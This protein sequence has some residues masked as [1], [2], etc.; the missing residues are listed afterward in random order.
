MYLGICESSWNVTPS[1]T[2]LGIYQFLVYLNAKVTPLQPLSSHSETQQSRM[3]PKSQQSKGQGK[4]SRVEVPSCDAVDQLHNVPMPD[5][6]GWVTHH[7]LLP[8]AVTHERKWSHSFFWIMQPCHE[9]TVRSRCCS[10]DRYVGIKIGKPSNLQNTPEWKESSSRQ[11]QIKGRMTQ[12]IGNGIPTPQPLSQ[13]SEFRSVR[14]KFRLFPH[15]SCWVASLNCKCFR[16]LAGV[17]TT[18][19]VTVGRTTT[20]INGYHFHHGDQTLI[21]WTGLTHVLARRNS[22]VHPTAACTLLFYSRTSH[23]PRQFEEI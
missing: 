1:P 4:D 2:I 6:T 7:Q 3:S 11:R 18:T 22:S 8:G 15:C 5:R 10:R 14:N 17:V 12:G 21:F 13:W 16:S 19:D 9:Q 20:E 23:P